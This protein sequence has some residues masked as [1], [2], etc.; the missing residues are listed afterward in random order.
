MFIQASDIR[1]DEAQFDIC[2]VGAGPTGI[3][4]AESLRTSNLRVALLESGTHTPSNEANELNEGEV[5]GLRFAGLT[6]GR[7]RAFGGAGHLWAGQCLELQS[8]DFEAR[9]WVPHSGWPI[10]K[11]SLSNWYRKAE[12]LLK[13]IGEKYDETN[14]KK[15]HL[16]NPLAGSSDLVPLFT[17]MTGYRNV[18]RLF[19]KKFQQAKN[20]TVILGAHALY[21]ESEEVGH[22]TGVR[23][24][25]DNRLTVV[26]AKNIVLC[27]GGIENARLLLLSKRSEAPAPGNTSGLVGKYFQD[28]P[29][30]FVGEFVPSNLRLIQDHFGLLYRGRTRYFPKFTLSEAIQRKYKVMNAAMHFEFAE[31]EGSAIDRAREL[32]RALRS[33]K[34]VKNVSI[35][36]AK[37][38]AKDIPDFMNVAA[39]RYIR[40][41]SP[42]NPRARVQLQVHLEQ[43]PNP[44]SQ[45]VLSEEL[46]RYGM[47]K[48]KVVWAL[49]DIEK[50]T[51][52]VAIKTASEELQ[53]CS[54]G[55][56]KP[57]P[58][59]S[60]SDW[61]HNL[62]DA[63]HH[64][65][66]TRM[67]LEASDG[68]V[69]SD[70]RLHDTKNVFVCGGSVFTTSG[71]ANP[72]LSMMALALRLGNHLRFSSG[73]FAE[74]GD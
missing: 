10:E 52:D 59:L 6:E 8:I 1:E 21:L 47:Q 50:H 7:A 40:G 30:A 69:N 5:G 2:I 57:Y 63:Y 12:E 54:L 13:V 20:I 56:L 23:I 28:H 31:P 60:S 18:G 32:V 51:L 73:E 71:F 22:V 33:K 9:D 35:R 34:N 62:Y 49:S 44:H 42:A 55:T 25:G 29:N 61:P 68:V 26:R 24:A 27:C 14:W 39:R 17:V 15:Q 37:H 72:T 64:A 16:T 4:L 70:L 43:A 38:A 45:I 48:A 11:K 53:K 36:F 65:G 58:W 66:T 74:V 19:T 46:D 41:L 3:A 67:S